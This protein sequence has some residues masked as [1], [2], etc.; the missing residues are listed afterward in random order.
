MAKERISKKMEVFPKNN[1]LIVG[2]FQ[3]LN[4][5]KY[6]VISRMAVASYNQFKQ[7]ERWLRIATLIDFAGRKLCLEV[8][9][10]KEH[11]PTDGALLYHMLKPY[12]SKIA[13]F[14]DQVNI[15]CPPNGIVDVSKFDLTLLTSIIETL[16]PG[17]YDN[18]VKGVRRAR[19][20]EYHRG[21]KRLSDNEFHD[22]WEETEQMLQNHGFDLR[23]VGDLKTCDLSNDCKFKDVAMHIFFQGKVK[24]FFEVF[25][26]SYI[27]LI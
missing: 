4:L 10:R 12:K 20:R 16:F 5:L 13:R 14:A 26:S 21:D 6:I 2:P 19:N 7:H 17:K 22:L 25:S 3:Q 9:H 18:L 24:M 23:L 15:L 8:L 11:L 1:I 27:N